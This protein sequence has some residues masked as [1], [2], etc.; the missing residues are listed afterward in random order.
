VVLV[1][2]VLAGTG[3]VLGVPGVSKSLK[4]MF[5]ATEI[6]IIDFQVKP[7]HLPVTVVEK[8]LL[9]SA[10]NQDVFCQVEG[11]TTIIMILPEG[12]RVTKDQLVCELDSS[13]LRDNLKNQKIATLGA[14]AAFQNAKLTRE[15]AAI[16]VIEY[17]EGI[18]KQELE[19]VLGEIALAEAERKR[20]EDRIE[21]S[22][23]MLEK[24]YVSL[25]QNVADKVSLKQKEFAYEQALTKKKV[26]LDFTRDKT[27]KELESE[28]EKAKSDELAKQQTWELEKD[29]EAKLDKQIKNCR[30]LAPGDGIVVYA[31]DPSRFGGSSQPQ[32]E[33]GAAVRERQKIFSLPD[34]SKMRVN[35][36]VHESMIDR[37]T[38]GLP[39]RIRVDA[40]ADAVLTG[41]VQ[42]VAPLP[43]PNSFFSSDIKV[44][45]TRITIEDA[46]S[47][48]GLRPGMSAQVEIL[49]TE[50]DN[51][52]A[53]PLQAI[54]EYKNKDHVA[55]KNPNGYERDRI[56]K[57][58][59]SND[60]LIEVKE[61]LKP[62]DVVAL[63]PIALMSEEEKREQFGSGKEGEQKDWGKAAKKAANALVSVTAANKEKAAATGTG[64]GAD[65]GKGKGKTGKGKGGGAMGGFFSKL[66]EATKA[67]FRSSSPEEKK[68]IMEDNGMPPEM[69]ERMLQGGFGGGGQRGGGGGGGGFGGPPG[70][71]GGGGFGGPP[72][73]GGS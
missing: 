63:N 13:A 38:P 69:I 25:A 9:E 2:I 44:Y 72:G 49:V 4:G 31:N 46:P 50:L 52:L 70:G 54:L 55:V 16:A 71:G 24:G 21:W 68:K 51:V 14:E 34:I 62:G 37:I 30:L 18:F 42:E 56:V 20:A 1:L 19:T 45:T 60:R 15:V 64:T 32:V 66:D 27:I 35:T 43:D 40:F 61:G 41:T 33:E 12:S 28:V 11:Q 7:T 65:K 3:V 8:G 29:K 26:L 39:A 59:I 57:L 73:G 36:K 23:R 47:T 67:R 5:A 53:I 10:E 22:T 17:T 48:L 58:G 6:P